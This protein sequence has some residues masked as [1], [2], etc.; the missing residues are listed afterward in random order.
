MIRSILPEL[1]QD[2]LAK[3]AAI[4]VRHSPGIPEGL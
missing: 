4:I 2:K 3:A 1:N